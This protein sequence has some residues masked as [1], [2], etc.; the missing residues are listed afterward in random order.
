M[1]LVIFGLPSFFLSIYYVPV[2]GETIWYLSLTAWLLWIILNKEAI[3]RACFTL[4]SQSQK[5]KVS[6]RCGRGPQNDR[7][8]G[9]SYKN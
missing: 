1:S 2:K 3:E 6:F 7:W 4:V 5:S 8:L 9:G